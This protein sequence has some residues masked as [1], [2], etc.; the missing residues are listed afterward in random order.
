MH[1]C[2]CVYV[3]AS[4]FVTTHIHIYIR[5]GKPPLDCFHLSRCL[6]FAREV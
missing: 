4:V 1:V 6:N 5:T 2:V 3:C